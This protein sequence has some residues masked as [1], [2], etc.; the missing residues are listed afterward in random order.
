MSKIIK[1]CELCGHEFEAVDSDQELCP[2][3]EYYQNKLAE[4]QAWEQKMNEHYYV[5]R[6]KGNI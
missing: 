6:Q 4:E 2:E 3:C 1:E 5:E